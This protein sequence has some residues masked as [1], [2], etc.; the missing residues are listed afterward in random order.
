MSIFWHE[1]NYTKIIEKGL[2]V[3]KTGTQNMGNGVYWL[4][5]GTP[6]NSSGQVANTANA[7][8][9]VAEDFYFYSTTPTLAK[10][11]KLIETGYVDLAL[12]EAAFGKSYTAEAKAALKTNGV[13]LVNKKVDPVDVTTY[14]DLLQVIKIEDA[15]MTMG[16]IATTLAAVNT[17]GDHV[18]FDVSALD[19]GMYLCTIFLN[20]GTYRIAD[21][22]TGY[23]GSGL[24]SVH[25]TSGTDDCSSSM[26]PAFGRSFLAAGSF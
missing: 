17:A 6:L 20:D 23:V 9:L 24:F 21:L 16:N 7:K 10:Q 14:D 22:V 1:D 3:I 4:R 5:A 2:P 26:I 11:V 25:I 8:Y 19:A 15:D 13:I 18:V 12:A